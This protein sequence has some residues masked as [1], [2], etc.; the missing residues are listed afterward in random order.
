MER[1][2]KNLIL[3][4]ISGSKY[5]L[6]TTIVESNYQ[7]VK[8]FIIIPILSFAPPQPLPPEGGVGVGH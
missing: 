4:K 1:V 8:K 6:K 2:T 5:T 3:F 7:G